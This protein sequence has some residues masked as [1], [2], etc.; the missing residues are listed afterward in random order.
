MGMKVER[1]WTW[2]TDAGNRTGVLGT[3]N[4]MLAVCWDDWNGGAG[5]HVAQLIDRV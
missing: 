4:V 3:K 2:V 5:E 1:M